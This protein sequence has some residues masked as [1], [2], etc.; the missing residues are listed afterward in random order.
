MFPQ[1]TVVVPTYRRPDLLGRALQSVLNQTYPRFVVHV[2]D[3]ASQDETE[4][5]VAAFTRRDARFQY[6][7]NETN[8]GSIRNT[9]LGFERVKTPYFC[10]L[11]D[12]DLLLPHF[13]ELAVAS[14]EKHPEAGFFGGMCVCIEGSGRPFLLSGTDDMDGCYPPPEA[15]RLLWEKGWPQQAGVLYRTSARDVLGGIAPIAGFDLEYMSRI[16]S[17]FAVVFSTTPVAFFYINQQSVSTSRTVRLVLEEWGYIRDA[18][19]GYAWLDAGTK[20]AVFALWQGRLPYQIR[21]MTLH[22]LRRGNV[23]DAAFGLTCLDRYPDYPTIKPVMRL[24]V[25][26][27]RLDR[28]LVALVAT[29]FDFRVWLFTSVRKIRFARRF[30]V[31]HP[32]YWRVA[33]NLS[34]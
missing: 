28:R 32:E 19:T 10:Y 4:Q 14:L 13:L 25:A 1:V 3:N 18:V 31:T 20:Q 22:S 15:L 24:A 9:T 6:Y 2:C 5:I 27:A 7:C 34:K 21:M 17:R 12:D 16:A 26:V 33:K 29:V 30:R 11:A 8:I 23:D